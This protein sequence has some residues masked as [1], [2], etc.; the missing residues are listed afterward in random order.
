MSEWL[1][2]GIVSCYRS[3][4]SSSVVVVSKKDGEKRVCAHFRKLNAV[5]KEYVVRLP[6]IDEILSKLGGAKYISTS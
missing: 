6:S 3:P 5:T 4:F 2:A 1:S